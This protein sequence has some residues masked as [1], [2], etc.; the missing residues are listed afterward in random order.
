ML[1]PG[2][3]FDLC[4]FLWYTKAS[5]LLD[6]GLVNKFVGYPGVVETRSWPPGVYRN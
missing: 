3:V 5:T 6:K 2:L 4:S 1:K